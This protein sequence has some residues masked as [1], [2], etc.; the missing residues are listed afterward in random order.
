MIMKRLFLVLQ[1][2][3][4][5]FCSACCNAGEHPKTAWWYDI[6]FVPDQTSING[7]PIQKLDTTWELAKGLSVKDLKNKLSRRDVQRFSSSPFSFEKT[8]DLN[9]NKQPETFMV[10][11]YR[12]HTGQTGKF[13]AIFEKKRLLSVFTANGTAG[14]SAL[15]TSNRQLHWYQ[16]ME[17]GE[18]ETLIWNGKTYALE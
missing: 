15:L 18:F 4:L 9:G 12:T 1:T 3:L 7:I 14:F 2:A 11:V 13:L 16:C 10:G 6:V 8:I 5:L 17:C